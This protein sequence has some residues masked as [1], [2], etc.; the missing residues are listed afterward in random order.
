LQCEYDSIYLIEQIL[1]YLDPLIGDNNPEMPS[2]KLVKPSTT[3]GK[4]VTNSTITK[5]TKSIMK[6]LSILS[7]SK[8]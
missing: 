3:T 1:C 4:S 8:I 5:V 6:I 7:I 2:T